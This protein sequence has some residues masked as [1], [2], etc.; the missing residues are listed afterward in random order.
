MG[1][2]IKPDRRIAPVGW[3]L[4]GPSTDR[5]VECPRPN[6]IARHHKFTLV[7]RR[8]RWSH[9]PHRPGPAVSGS[10]SPARCL[11]P[12]GGVAARMG[13]VGAELRPSGSRPARDV[14]AARV[15]R[16][17]GRCQPGPPAGNRSSRSSRRVA[18]GG[19]ESL[20]VTLGVEHRLHLAQRLW[21]SSAR[22]RRSSGSAVRLC[23]SNTG[24]AAGAANGLVGMPWSAFQS[25]R[26]S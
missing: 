4:G 8:L 2:V 12:R 22:L 26:R 3:N 6:E 20:G 24:S 9:G 5:H 7:K 19:Q 16:E 18:M 10:R 17:S 25:S 21:S 23:I 14:A 13:P 11:G 15:V 1:A